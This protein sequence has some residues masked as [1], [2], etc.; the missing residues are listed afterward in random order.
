MTVPWSR[1]R[2]PKTTIYFKKR[3]SEV[4]AGID[5]YG[6]PEAQTETISV[7]CYLEKTSKNSSPRDGMDG[8]AI[9]LEGYCVEPKT[10]P[11]GIAPGT[12][13]EASLNLGVSGSEATLVNGSFKLE[14]NTE[15]TL[16]LE[17]RIAKR[18]GQR[19]KGTF[20]YQTIWGEGQD[21]GFGF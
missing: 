20:Y 15:Y 7:I 3:M 5:E 1:K 2:F 9:S 13:A 14:V 12:I 16:G 6:N 17:E 19:I 10:L 11:P 18:L 8:N 21:G 4:G